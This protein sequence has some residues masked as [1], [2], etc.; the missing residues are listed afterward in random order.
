ME[1]T[2]IG[3]QVSG[4]SKCLSKE[5]RETYRLGVHMTMWG[6]EQKIAAGQLESLT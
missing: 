3:G 1:P 4:I 6:G 2:W 5:T